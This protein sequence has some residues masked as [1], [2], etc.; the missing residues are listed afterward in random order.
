[1]RKS[2]ETKHYIIEPFYVHSKVGQGRMSFEARPKFAFAQP[3]CEGTLNLKVRYPA[4]WASHPITIQRLIEKVE[5]TEDNLT[6]HE[7]QN[8]F[9]EAEII[10]IV[11]GEK[12]WL[13]E[14]A[15]EELARV[16]P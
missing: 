3:S 15:E 11:G 16:F 4:L 6:V 2:V 9:D 8:L 13:E 14:A 7:W 10:V 5:E 1:M 12:L